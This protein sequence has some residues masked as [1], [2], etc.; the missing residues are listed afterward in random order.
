MTSPWHEHV[1]RLL[2]RWRRRSQLASMKDVEGFYRF[3]LGRAPDRAGIE[4]Y[5][6]LIRTTGP[7]ADDLFEHFAR[8]PEFRA[9]LDELYRWM[10]SDLSRV[11]L[12]AGYPFYV[13]ATGDQNISGAIREF[14]HYEPLVSR[15]LRDHLRPGDC[16]VD[17]GA[18]IGYFSVLAGRI[19]G[20]GGRVVACEPGP[21][22][23]N[24]L[25]LNLLTNDLSNVE[26]FPVA[27][28]DRNEI[29]VYQRLGHNGALDTD[30]ASEQTI[31]TRDLVKVT[32]MDDLL[33]GSEHIDVMKID[34]EGAEGK[35]LRG[36]EGILRRF[37]PVLIFEFTPS[38]L[39]ELSGVSGSELLENLE[40]LGYRFNVLAEGLPPRRGRSPSEAER[41][42]A[43]E[44]LEDFSYLGAQHIDVLA[45]PTPHLPSA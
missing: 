9:R 30:S 25:L 21:Q 16:F 35:V 24:A 38:G 11:D 18:S 26:V 10:P 33:A 42:D 40:S 37:H 45:S 14:G 29:A 43:S 41:V 1:A 27:L 3:L 28:G 15:A 31:M 2:A 12:D 7:S 8:S 13:P 39:Q 19:V 34:V 6:R 32:R 17:V 20:D 36:A 22:N 5:R 4:N 44:V 23:Q